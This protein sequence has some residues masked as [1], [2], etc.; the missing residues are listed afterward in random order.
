MKTNSLLLATL[1]L[2]ALIYACKVQMNAK[3]P[4]GTSTIVSSEVVS[5]AESDTTQP[6][7]PF[8]I[9]PLTPE[10]SQRAFV[11]PPGYHME[12]VASEPMITEPVAI[13]WD[14]DARMY[15]AQME[16]YTQDADGTGT[17]DKK[18]RVMLLEDTNN[19][20][21]MD[22]STVFIKDML[23]P[24]M[25]LCVN[26]ELLVNETDTYDIF[27]YKDTNGDGVADQKRP[28]YVVGKVAPGNLEHQRSGLVWNLDNYIYQTVDPIRFRYVN[29]MLKP[30]S[31]HSGSN[32]QWGL[33]Y[34]NYGRLFFS[35]GGGENAGSG[36]QINPKYG[37]LEFA[38]AYDEA[39]FS[40]VWSR[41]SNPEVQGGPPRL[42]P[43]STLNHFTSGNGQ[44]IFR[45]DRLPADLVGDYLINE[46]VARIIRRAKVVNRAGKTQLENVYHNKEFIA[47][48][49][50][51]FRPVNT[52][53]GPDGL[54]YIIDMNR[55]IIQESN[56][57]QKG[58]FLRS[59]IDYYDLAKINQRG[60]IWRLVH[61]DF[62]PGPK[63]KMLDVPAA[64]L[65]KYLD[66]PNGWWRD[67][68]QK[69]LIL[70]GDK[71]VVSDLRAMVTGHKNASA[72]GRLHALWTLEGLD[73]IDKDLI[74][75]TLTDSD[76]QVRR[77]AIWVSERY[78]KQ[79][80]TD[81]IARVGKLIDDPN[82]DV[83]T[84]LLLSLGSNKNPQAQ[85]IAQEILIRNADNEMLNRVKKSI[86]RN[87]DS[88]IYG[89]KL[90]SFPAPDR[91]LI[92]AGSEIYKGM[93]SPC[94]GGDGNGLPTNAAP[95]LRG[96]KHVNHDRDFVIRILL[97]GL[98]GPIDGKAFPSEMASMKD[99]SDEWI[100]SVLSYIRYE[101]VG[102]SSR[103][104]K[105]RQSAVI[106][107]DDVKK[108]RE[109]YA[110]SRGAWTIDELEKLIIPPPTAAK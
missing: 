26:H 7:A 17:K 71:S 69:Q 45:G 80:D 98:K 105:G 6:L 93:C 79:N 73:S 9:V 106:Q 62:K 10:Q 99:N 58:T 28:V 42:R 68:A 19:D 40:P 20:G 44:S 108:V 81:M 95:A 90:G 52:Y 50:F 85:Q 92:V 54:L 3:A 24:R 22:K 36:F 25:L 60:R 4:T 89:M 74:N 47:S 37:A 29:G 84:Q 21:K 13:A 34:D 38:D 8:S 103:A 65:I 104:V 76:A 87:E 67:N 88:K 27:S 64:S 55:G 12:L 39:T 57:T 77:A 91:K 48:T 110:S 107:P 16:T 72:L 53:T 96:A 56:W 35:R 5:K 14:G 75:A 2:S 63:P 61:D 1:G 30:D 41:I 66:H 23:L 82:Y 46:P 100:A 94:H 70:L 32:G 33:T 101:F 86:D 59:K 31:L 15:V 49:D 43:D 109:M 97:H 51:F 83:R 78:L 11:L 102:T 18:S